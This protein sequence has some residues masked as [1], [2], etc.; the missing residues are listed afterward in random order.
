MNLNRS[1]PGASYATYCRQRPSHRAS[2]RKGDTL[3]ALSI[4]TARGGYTNRMRCHSTLPKTIPQTFRSTHSSPGDETE[5][6]YWYGLIE[7][8]GPGASVAYCR[9]YVFGNNS[10]LGAIPARGL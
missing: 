5:A 8:R 10:C 9:L 2:G 1:R 3:L 4:S 6:L 7:R